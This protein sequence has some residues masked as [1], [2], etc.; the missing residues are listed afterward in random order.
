MGE[1]LY[2]SREVDNPYDKR[3]QLAIHRGVTVGHVPRYVSRGFSLF[4]QLGGNISYCYCWEDIQETFLP[5]GGLEI[6]CQY[7][8]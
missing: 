4:I 6:P 5:Q 2:C 3:S 1:I 8:L 7:T